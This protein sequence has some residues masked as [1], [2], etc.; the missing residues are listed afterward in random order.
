MLIRDEG[1]T[2]F[3]AVGLVDE[4]QFTYCILSVC[5]L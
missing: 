5:L 3:T 4:Q 2:G 1:G